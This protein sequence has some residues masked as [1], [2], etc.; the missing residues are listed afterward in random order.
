MATF[1]SPQW[2]DEY[3]EAIRSSDELLRAADA[4]EGDITLVVDAEPDKNVPGDVW[5]WFHLHRGEFLGARLVGPDEGERARFVIRASYSVWKDVIQG[6]I[7]PVRGMT[8]GKLKLSGD[9]PLLTQHLPAV[10][11][12]VTLAGAITTGFA[13][14]E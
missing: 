9:L 1:P 11:Q 8:Q 5:A 10:A 7:E 12:L 13:D 2:L 6:R 4:W 3:A 14:D